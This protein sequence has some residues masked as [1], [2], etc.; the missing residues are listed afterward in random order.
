MF[1]QWRIL[2]WYI[3]FCR[4]WECND[5]KTI[6]TNLWKMW[7]INESEILGSEQFLFPSPS[8]LGREQCKHH[9][10]ILYRSHDLSSYK[11][12]VVHWNIENIMSTYHT[13]G[14]LI[15][16]A[17]W[18]CFCNKPDGYGLSIRIEAG[19]LNFDIVMKKLLALPGNLSETFLWATNGLL[20]SPLF[21][22][23]LIYIFLNSCYVLE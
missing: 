21:R 1:W 8:C 11:S 23:F 10:S 12:P 13:A 14:F 17:F 22:L 7:S 19:P 18:T 4:K 9:P 6:C 20:V 5:V 3:H 15:Y 16:S 2:C